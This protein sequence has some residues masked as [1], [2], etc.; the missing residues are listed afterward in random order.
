MRNSPRWFHYSH[1]GALI[2]VTGED[3][4]TFLQGQF[5]NELRSPHGSV[6]YGLW[7]NQKGKVLA[8]SQV[9]RRAENEFTL[10]S[11]TSPASVII[12]RLEQYVIA[13]DVSLADETG[14]I[15]ELT[16]WGD[17][18]GERLKTL[19]GA[20][21]EERK[22]LPKD[23]LVI[24]PGRRTGGENYQI[25]GPETLMA[26]W[27]KKL[28]TD[29]WIE[30]T[31]DLLEI[32]RISAGFPAV[33]LDVGPTD[34]P[35]E[36]GLDRT[37]ISYTK[38]CYLGQEVMARLKNL[39]QVRRQLRGVRGTGVAPASAT[40]LFQGEKKVGEIRSAVTTEQGFVAMAMLTRMGLDENA[41]FSLEA[42]ESAQQNVTVWMN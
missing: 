38:G 7:L 17:E 40:P 26:D 20:L 33:P 4:F 35:N 41:G 31:A 24:I 39:G 37:A 15:A 9:L 2:K 42:A 32:A 28:V 6:T 25:F 22:F 12:Q 13:D 3:A 16:L 10:F 11:D 29:G 21:P 19:L 34:L 30:A 36:A 23:E 8:D 27:Q 14:T 18:C 1:P 5:T